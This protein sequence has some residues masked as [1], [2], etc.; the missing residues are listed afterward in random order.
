M[1]WWWATPCATLTLP[2]T[3]SF[4]TLC[5][6][7]SENRYLF[8]MFVFLVRNVKN[9]SEGDHPFLLCKMKRSNIQL[10]IPISALNTFE[11]LKALFMDSF[12]HILSSL[13][14]GSLQQR[15]GGSHLRK[16]NMAS[17]HIQI[18]GATARLFLSVVPLWHE[19]I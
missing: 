10:S 2:S 17:F 9:N 12:S 3:P 14:H 15:F 8:V 16:R 18:R 7:P 13:R 4:T 19:V 5:L 6:R 1:Q 11:F